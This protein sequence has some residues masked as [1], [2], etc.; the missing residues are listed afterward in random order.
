VIPALGAEFD[1]G[2]ELPEDTKSPNNKCHM[3]A[4]AISGGSCSMTASSLKPAWATQ[5][6]V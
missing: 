2:C 5:D 1:D 3:E 6:P 4:Q